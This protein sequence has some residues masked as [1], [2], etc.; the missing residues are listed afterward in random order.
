MAE[1]VRK[2]LMEMMEESHAAL[3]AV[4]EQVDLEKVLHPESGWRGREILSHI[5]AWDRVMAEALD[6]FARGDVLVIPDY[7]EDRYNLEAPKRQRDL[8]TGQI[9]ADW[10]A[11][12][13]E[14]IAALRAMPE[15]KFS[16][17]LRYPWGDEEGSI[18]VLL[19]YFYGHDYEHRDEFEGFIPG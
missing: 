15:E 19:K 18:Y 17:D 13:G 2:Q 11:A 16:E 3:L 1:D 9:V 8:S 4:V 7:D 6:A 12:R 14:L 10:K 5:G